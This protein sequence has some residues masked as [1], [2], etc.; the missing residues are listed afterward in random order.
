M[1]FSLGRTGDGYSIVNGSSVASTSRLHRYHPLRFEHTE[2][3]EVRRIQNSDSD[4]PNTHPS[5]A[6]F[7]PPL[8]GLRLYPSIILDPFIWSEG[9]DVSGIGYW[10]LSV[11]R[12]RQPPYEASLVQECRCE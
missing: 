11:P 10:T 5:F 12:E 2:F 3:I 7:T 6:F 4:I 8:L 1:K 9:V